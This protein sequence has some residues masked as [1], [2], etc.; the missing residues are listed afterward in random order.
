MKLLNLCQVYL[1]GR[2]VHQGISVTGTRFLLDSSTCA[3]G[4]EDMTVVRVEEFVL[5]HYSRQG[6]PQGEQLTLR[7][8][9]ISM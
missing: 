3:A 9:A 2:V 6:Y 5:D 4:G 1:E 8:I 7:K